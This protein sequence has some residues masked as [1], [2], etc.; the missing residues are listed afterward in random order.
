MLCREALKRSNQVP[1]L[2][3]KKS[4]HCENS[5]RRQ[6]RT[7]CSLFVK[8]GNEAT[9]A[10]SAYGPHR[11][12]YA[13]TMPG[14]ATNDSLLADNRRTRTFKKVIR[15]VSK[16]FFSPTTTSAAASADAAFCRL[17]ICL[18]LTLPLSNCTF[19]VVSPFGY[20][21]SSP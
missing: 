19:E 16:L 3:G 17:I 14:H 21:F 6:S 11:G 4:E 8:Y 5:S 13:T 1:T 2:K 18:N 12:H 7:V 9:S 20:V 10:C 15:P